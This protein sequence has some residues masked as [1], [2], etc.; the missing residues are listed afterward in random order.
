ME[1]PVYSDL[2]LVGF[3]HSCIKVGGAVTFNVGVYQEGHLG[4][5]TVKQIERVGKKG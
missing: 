5:E 1:P 2:E 4:D 3:L